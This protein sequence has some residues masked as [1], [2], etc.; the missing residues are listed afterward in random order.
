MKGRELLER[1][2][3]YIIRFRKD[4]QNECM[5]KFYKLVHDE[6]MSKNGNDLIQ[7]AFDRL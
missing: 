7:N 3:P 2:N 6:C 5:G 4:K 1:A